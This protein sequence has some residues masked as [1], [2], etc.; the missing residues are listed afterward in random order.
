MR[1]LVALSLVVLILASCS[2]SGSSGVDSRLVAES[3]S[4][5]GGELELSADATHDLESLVALVCRYQPVEKLLRQSM[6]FI[7]YCLNIEFIAVFDPDGDDVVHYIGVDETKPEEV[8]WSF[9]PL[10]LAR[11]AEVL[12]R[13]LPSV[14]D[15]H[16]L[17]LERVFVARYLMT[18]RANPADYRRLLREF[19]DWRPA[20][21][22]ATVSTFLFL[23]SHPRIEFNWSTKAREAIRERLR[24]L[25]EEAEPHLLDAERDEDP[26]IASRASMAI[27]Q[28]NHRVDDKAI[29]A[30]RL[31]A[32][33]RSLDDPDL[34]VRQV[35][36]D[37]F[38]FRGEPLER[39]TRVWI[40]TGYYSWTG[41]REF[42][43]H[44]AERPERARLTSQIAKELASSEDEFVQTSALA[45]L[46]LL[47]DLGVR[48][49]EEALA[50]SSDKIRE[51]AR[52]ELAK[53]TP[54][55]QL[56]EDVRELIESQLRDR[57]AFVLE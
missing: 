37:W 9:K 3:E 31:R 50:S 52:E 20:V 56:S 19:A 33:L 40:E 30:K 14:R 6:T 17:V 43:L 46:A 41:Q 21:R 16:A 35:A 15:A 18:V 4:C 32:A 47:A 53:W 1:I 2:R 54:W 55:E 12:R 51:R 42:A 11:V 22:R 45:V 48:S 27:L 13:R 8:L 25:L 29:P 28:L 7:Q 39:S 49:A 10:S 23:A 24:P 34:L 44:C 36:A 38:L 5:K 26:I 57:V